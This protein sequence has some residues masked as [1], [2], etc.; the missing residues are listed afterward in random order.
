MDRRHLHL[1]RRREPARVV[2]TENVVFEMVG[3]RE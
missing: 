1:P 3:I 2:C